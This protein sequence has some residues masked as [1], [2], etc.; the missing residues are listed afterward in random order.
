MLPT[1]ATDKARA[2]AAGKNGAYVWEAPVKTRADIDKIQTPRASVD[3]EAT[4][5][6]PA[7]YQELLGDIL[8]V[9][10]W[11]GYWWALGLIDE[12]T[13]LRGITPTFW[14]MADD[15]GF[16]HAGMQRL[17]E[18][19]LAWLAQRF[20]NRP[21]IFGWELWNEVNAV[22]AKPESYLPWTQTML[23]ELHRLFPRNLAMRER[24][25]MSVPFGAVI[26]EFA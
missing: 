16:V 22:A 20:G 17:M 6:N 21:E 18:G 19:K 4:Q 3:H 26:T 5:R 23:A 24:L 12:W 13:F 9:R 8:E 25:G 11:S 7:Y 14:D 2:V 15:P 1:V 10:V